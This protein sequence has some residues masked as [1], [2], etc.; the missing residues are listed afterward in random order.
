MK[1]FSK[2]LNVFLVV[3]L[4]GMMAACSSNSKETSSAEKIGGA[5]GTK[6][7]KVVINIAYGNQP[8]EPIDQLANKWKELAAEK[9]GGK[10]E[11]KLYPS[12]QLG[13]EKDVVEQATMGNNVIVMAGYDFL[14]DYVPDAGILTAPYITDSVDDLLYLTTTDWF[15]EL[16]TSLNEK[17]LDIVVTK[18]VYGER[19]LLTNDPVLKPED[20]KGMKIR[21][22]N[23]QMSIAT[24]EALGATPTPTPL[25]DLYTSLQ[26]GLIDGAENPLPV[27]AG[28]KAQEVSKHLALT[29]HQKFITS[30]VGGAEFIQ[31]L[32][33][34]VVQILRETG[35]EAADFAR[36]VLEE[37]NEQVLTDFQS[38][39]VEVHEVD[40]APFK[41]KVKPVYEAFPNWTPGLY[42]RI[43]ELVAS[44]K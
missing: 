21:V 11:L 43:Q 30:W 36:G 16:N 41:D 29:G 34:D 2:W 42:D 5:E 4:V 19:H 32:P 20:L 44:Q 39:G 24:F 14:M 22:P 40:I 8:G 1:K 37:Q 38:Q 31:S 17:G 10:I 13:S 12:S 9:S 6:D 35:N 23:N 33:E 3:M 15:K 28:V 7:E 27:L 18:T 26:Q 25:G